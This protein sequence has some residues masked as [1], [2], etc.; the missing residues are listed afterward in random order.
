MHALV[1]AWLWR[2]AGQA[3]AEKG[4]AQTM[5]AS[6]LGRSWE[7]RGTFAPQKDEGAGP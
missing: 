7:P 3:C 4:S 2:A 1:D 5:V 6:S